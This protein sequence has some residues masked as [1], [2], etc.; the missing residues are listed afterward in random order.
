MGG[1]SLDDNENSLHRS[2]EPE[3]SQADDA[4]HFAGLLD[5]IINA[6][7][8]GLW[9]WDLPTGRVSYSEQW[10]RILGYEKGEMVQ[11]ASVWESAVL[12]EDLPVANESLARYLAGE[13]SLYEAAYRVRRKDGAI[14]WVQGRGT[15]T[16]RDEEG[17][18]LRFVGILQDITGIKETEQELR[19]TTE[20]LDFIASMSGLA[21]WDWD[22][23]GD[24]VTF[25]D[26]Y[27][28]MLGY[29]EMA[30]K[31]TYEEWVGFMHPDDLE[32]LKHAIDDCVNGRADRY[33]QEIRLRHRDGHYIWAFDTGRVVERDSSGTPV[34]LLG[35]YLNI[36]KIKETESRLK[37]ALAENER[38]S[39][40]L[41]EDVHVAVRNLESERQS[42]Q[43][44]FD[45]NPNVGMI[46]D[47]QFQVIDCNPAAMEYY[48]FSD[49]EDFRS[50]FF[51]VLRDC[52]PQTQTSGEYTTPFDERVR[53]ALRDGS[54]EFETSL[55]IRGEL[56]PVH[57]TMKTIRQGEGFAIAM[58]QVD[59]RKI[60]QAENELLRQDKLLKAVND[61]AS[62]LMGSEQ[63][64]F[65]KVM[66][67]A[68]HTLGESIDADRMYIWKN[69]E[70]DGRLYC[71]QVYLCHRD[72]IP[73][74]LEREQ[75][76][77]AYDEVSPVWRE[78]LA[79]GECINVILRD[80]PEDI[81]LHLG[82]EAAKSTL[83]IPMF[84]RN[85]FWGLVG[86][87]DCRRER[88]FTEPEENV[89]KSG[90]LLLAS[91]IVRNEM[92]ENLIQAREEALASTRAKS[93]FLANMSH[94]IRTPMNAIIGMSA[95]ARGS[96]GNID[97]IDDCLEKIGS[98]SKHLLGVI[99]DV[100]DMSK[101]EARK[102]ELSE[103]PFSFRRMVKSLYNINIG[104]VEDKSQTL[105]MEVADD[106]P[107]V[108]VGDEVRLSQVITNLLSNAI[109][110]TPGGGFIRFEARQLRRE[111]DEVMLEMFVEDTGIG[112]EEDK[113]DKLFSAFEQADVGITRNY[114]GTGLGL[115]ISKSIVEQMGGS[116]R[117]E[118][119]YGKGSRF[120]F[121]IRIGWAED[122]DTPEIEEGKTTEVYDFSG[123][124][125]LLV[126]D[127]E[128]NR[129]IVIT[130][131]ESTGVKIES[132]E[133]G[134]EALE[135]VTANP[136]R[137]DLIFMDIHMP[138]MD[139]YEAT[140]R[141]RRLNPSWAAH[142]P[143]VA[144]TANAF[145]EDIQR[146]K[147]AGMDDHLAKPIDLDAL[148]ETIEK[149][150][151]LGRGDRRINGE[152]RGI[153]DRRGGAT[154]RRSGGDRRT[155]HHQEE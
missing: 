133:N 6:T 85:V 33:Y 90:G 115:A 4:A 45:A 155:K 126:E 110:F 50:D 76:A 43:A 26:R 36:D 117:I 73:L 146:C 141:I 18:P 150:I 10:E 19:Q 24:T 75:K 124:T 59:L 127:I 123:R 109:K 87:D 32:S 103:E 48:G 108:L 151:F 46:F 129:T 20:Q 137:Y 42:S 77:I 145:A 21:S 88:H 5:V 11:Q 119:E 142:V 95:I 91:A 125:I 66:I 93:A 111:G 9:D 8:I 39:E 149:Y 47:D 136:D 67:H 71:E 63:D 147:Q 23:R 86:F 135:M 49:K 62:L 40:R 57:M 94:E 101:I 64:S 70:K 55:I 1:T 128:I 116:I 113:L 130:L 96:G 54:H 114:G 80:M 106:V 30:V 104:K 41:R 15:F 29:T 152:R 107:R 112:I 34:R 89:M 154:D 7:H 97:K 3:K 56:T 69:Y 72:R 27:L 61:M 35:G 16:E 121:T 140:R 22:L 132:A 52:I 68:L 120:V 153:A 44:L 31:G 100:L 83:L 139:G 148:L 25:S 81:R 51:R 92:T 143:I 99:N 131:L 74:M 12:P 53:L 122:D 102:F 14:I 118:S 78:T 37:I 2:V 84:F 82:P 58:Y 98:A 65:D 13:T 60:R 134:L 17:N 138:M 38:H 28:S 79:K 144:M 105:T